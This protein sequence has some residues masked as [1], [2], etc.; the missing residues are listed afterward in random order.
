MPPLSHDEQDCAGD[1]L[2]MAM[3]AMMMSCNLVHLVNFYEIREYTELGDTDCDTSPHPNST[4]LLPPLKTTYL[5]LD[6]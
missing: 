1:A 2:L 4:T 3:M 6:A 5:C